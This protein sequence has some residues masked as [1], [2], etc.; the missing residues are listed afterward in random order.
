MGQH[1][2]APVGGRRHHGAGGPGHGQLSQAP[3]PRGRRVPGPGPHHPGA[4]HAE[5][6]QRGERQVRDWLLPGLRVPGGVGVKGE[7]DGGYF[8]AGGGGQVAGQGQGAEG[9]VGRAGWVVFDQAQ[10]GHHSTPRSASRVSSA[11][12]ASGPVPRISAPV[13]VSAGTRRRSLR[14]PSGCHAGVIVSMGARLARRRPGS[15]G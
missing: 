5:L 11:G 4:G 8:A 14:R 6:G 9:G 2:A 13:R 7:Q 3:R 1:F 15:D 12:T 10:D